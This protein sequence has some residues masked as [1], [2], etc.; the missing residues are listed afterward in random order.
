M[1]RVFLARYIGP[2]SALQ[3]IIGHCFETE[4][5]MKNLD[6]FVIFYPNNGKPVYGIRCSVSYLEILGKDDN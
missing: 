1:K 3:N 2:N 6:N 4:D 5:T